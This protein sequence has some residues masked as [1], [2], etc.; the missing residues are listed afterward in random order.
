MISRVQILVLVSSVLL[1]F[2]V[3]DLIRRGR[4]RERYSLIWLAGAL[5]I[6]GFGLF[7][8]SINYLGRLLEV[9]YAPSLL[10]MIVILII[11]VIHLTHTVSI[12]NLTAQ[13]RDLC[14]KIATLELRMQ[15]TSLYITPRILATIAKLSSD[16]NQFNLENHTL[17]VRYDLPVQKI[18]EITIECLLASSGSI[19][20]LDRE[21][22]PLEAV[23]YFE[24]EERLTTEK[25]LDDTIRQGLAGWVIENRQPAL[26]MHTAE[27]NR[28][29]KRSWDTNI[30]GARSALS[31]PLI[32]GGQLLGV[33]TLV[34]KGARS[35]S[36]DDLALLMAIIEHLLLNNTIPIYENMVINT[37][38]E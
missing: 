24:G 8:G 37:P 14:Q 12:S 33:L 1:F 19:V 23:T 34:K 6:F 31:V 26:V 16:G 25:E 30:G 11:V 22:K 9:D 27:D 20:I 18:L 3:L 13:N 32:S 29:L 4:L 15:Q 21:K 38:V 10:F 28:W 36:T 17:K 2:F 5:I 35:Y 7:H